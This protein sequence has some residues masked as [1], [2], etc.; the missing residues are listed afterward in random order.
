MRRD[1]NIRITNKQRKIGGWT[2]KQTGGLTDG[3]NK[4]ADGATDERTDRHKKL[5][6]Y[7]TSK[8]YERHIFQKGLK[9]N[10]TPLIP[11]HASLNWMEEVGAD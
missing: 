4:L 10:L 11:L 6:L 9:E 3:R 2:H 8:C 5:N 1:N 7:E